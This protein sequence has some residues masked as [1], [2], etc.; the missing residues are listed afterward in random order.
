MLLTATHSLCDR[1]FFPVCSATGLFRQTIYWPLYLFSRYMRDGISVRVSIDS[2]AFSGET[3]PTWISS[4]K[5]P[6]SELDVS[7]IIHTS[8]D[9]KRSLRVAVVNRS[10]NQS[11]DVPIRV[12]FEETLSGIEVEVHELWHQDVNA[13]NDWGKE[14]E[15]SVKTRKK[16]WDGNWTFRE[17][18]FTLLV[19]TLDRDR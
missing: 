2:P 9:G 7:A 13:R 1:S 4:I 6:P 15:V 10:E 8:L 11:F 16:E 14:E 18:S 5:E 12:A 17:H 3:L 19:L